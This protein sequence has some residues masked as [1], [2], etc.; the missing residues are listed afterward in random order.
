[1]PRIVFIVPSFPRLS[2]TFIVNKVVGLRRQGWDVYVVCSES[3]LEERKSFGRLLDDDD[4]RRRIKVVWPHQSRFL[5]ALLAPFSFVRCLLLN[6]RG[7]VTYVV[8]GWERYGFDVLRR[9]YLDAELISLKPDLI[10][11]EF[12]ALAVGRT[13]LKALLGCKLVVSFR[14]YDL[15]YM[16]LDTPDY[17][18]SVWK[19]ADAVHF[20]G[21]DLWS[22]AQRR[23]CQPDKQRFLIPPAIDTNFFSPNGRAHTETVGA[24][25]RPLRILSVGRLDWRKGYDYA[26]QAI[27][28][29]VDEG[30]ACEYRIVGAGEYLEAIAFGRHQL[31]LEESVQLLE[32]QTPEQIKKHML[33]ADI[34]VHAAVSEGFCNAVLESQSMALPVVCTDA[35]G[36][37]ENVSD[38]ETGFVVPRRDPAQL[39]QRMLL[40]ARDPEL[41]ERLGDAGRR[42]VLAHFELDAQIA[43]FGDLYNKV[44]QPD[45]LPGDV[46][47]L[48]STKS[49]EY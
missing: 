34:L 29:L 18:K 22:R 42:R 23:G 1:M 47:G 24:R 25:E 7:T 38:G 15:N 28:L 12:G 43:D 49:L 10:H 11:F 48:L 14:G 16:G 2:E 30:I 26:L 44:L 19:R 3:S 46:P 9:F 27:R 17:Y 4:M 36:L 32:A 41:R 8:R 21:Q 35:G 20:L 13:Y 45:R 6:S 33:W 39:A 37:P 31:A 5:T 40:L